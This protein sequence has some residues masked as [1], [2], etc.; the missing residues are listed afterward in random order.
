MSTAI[1]ALQAAL[2]R[3]AAVRPAVGGFPYLAEALRQGGV[4]RC[5]MAVPA[6]AFVYLT[7]K[8][9]VAVQGEPLFS[10]MAQVPPFD[11]QALI[12]ALRAD[13]AGRT[14]FPEFVQGC[15]RAGVLWYDVDLAARTCTYY[16]AEGESYTE[17]YPAVDL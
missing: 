17:T 16:G 15:W 10:G 11:E 3:G 7:D 4:G 12:Q 14:A 8:G 5:R 9:P 2:D 6:N 13:Q 1:T